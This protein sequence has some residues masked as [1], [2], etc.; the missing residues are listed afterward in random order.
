[1]VIATALILTPITVLIAVVLPGNAVLPFGDLATIPFV[2]AFVVG[3]ARGNI[4]HSVIVGSVMIALSL[5][6]AT[7]IAPLFSDMAST[8]SINLPE[9]SAM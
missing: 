3:A 1:S 5:Y 6:M 9:G 8:A 4:I 7:D 2:V